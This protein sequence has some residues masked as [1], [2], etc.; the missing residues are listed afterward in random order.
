MANRSNIESLLGFISVVNISNDS[1]FLGIFHYKLL[2]FLET[3][4]MNIP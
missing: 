3:L 4:T 1:H 2:I